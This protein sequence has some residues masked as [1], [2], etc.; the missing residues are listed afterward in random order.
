MWTR[1][2]MDTDDLRV[3]DQLLHALTIDAL[4]AATSDSAHLGYLVLQATTMDRSLV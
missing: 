3:P 2:M 1:R 4:P